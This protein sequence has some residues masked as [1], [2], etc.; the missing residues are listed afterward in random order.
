M[1]TGNTLLVKRKRATLRIPA[2]IWKRNVRKEAER[3]EARLGF[4]GPE[5]HRVRN[6][7]VTELAATAQAASPATVAASVGLKTGRV[8]E[9]LDEL[10]AGLTFLYR[11]NGDDVDWA[12]PTAAVETPHRVT[13]DSGERFF[14]A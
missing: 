13:L 2:V 5:H 1:W 9:I 3:A 8:V 10:E 12:Y 4:M 7:V 14:A 6:F 11:T